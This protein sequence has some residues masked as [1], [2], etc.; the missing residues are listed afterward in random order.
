LVRVTCKAV[1]SGKVQGVSYRV[2]L[3]QRAMHGRV[4]GWVKNR[5][6]G[7]VETVLQGEVDDVQKV[8]DWAEVGPPGARVDRVETELLNAHPDLY[9]FRIFL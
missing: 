6:D 5:P 1:I 8:L 4:D 3:R 9:G 2:S 7:S